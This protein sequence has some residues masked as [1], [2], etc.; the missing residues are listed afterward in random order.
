MARTADKM[1]VNCVHKL[2]GWMADCWIV[3]TVGQVADCL[4]AVPMV[5]TR[6]GSRADK[7]STR[8]ATTRAY[9]VAVR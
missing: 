6:V 3:P 2:V 9:L 7:N 4:L 5:L 8:G 1:A